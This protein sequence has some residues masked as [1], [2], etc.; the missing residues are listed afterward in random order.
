MAAAH[1]LAHQWRVVLGEAVISLPVIIGLG[2][3]E[4]ELEEEEEPGLAP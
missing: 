4:S 1:L 2:L 3:R